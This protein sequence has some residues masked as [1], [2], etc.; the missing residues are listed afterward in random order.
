MTQGLTSL[1][2]RSLWRWPPVDKVSFFW[3]DRVP[4]TRDTYGV[5]Q[6]MKT[7]HPGTDVR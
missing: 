5:R 3:L 7:Y 2:T 1:Q 4:S 6:Q